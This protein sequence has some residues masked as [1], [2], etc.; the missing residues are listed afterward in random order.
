MGNPVRIADLARRMINLMGRTVKEGPTSDGDIEIV[1]TGLRPAEKLFEELLI[2]ANATGTDHPMIV[3][4]NEHCLPWEEVR[5]T[6]DEMLTNLNNFDCHRAR[7]VLERVVEEYRPLGGIQDL[8]WVNKA[9]ASLATE[10]SNVT[11]L[12]K[13][14]GRTGAPG[15]AGRSATH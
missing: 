2:G 7:E 11:T 14:R 8:V 10:A 1:Y 4:A 12:Q 9:G 13:R 3:R 15:G 5:A 6:L